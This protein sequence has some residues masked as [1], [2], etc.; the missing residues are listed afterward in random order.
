MFL[1]PFAFL[2]P[3]KS[4]E[5]VMDLLWIAIAIELNYLLPPDQAD[6]L[7]RKI[8]A[9]YERMKEENDRT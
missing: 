6:T 8:K 2:I 5:C 9:R 3:L 1:S 4:E 7:F